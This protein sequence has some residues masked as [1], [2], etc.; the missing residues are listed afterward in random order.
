MIKIKIVCVGKLKED[1]YLKAQAEYVKMLGRFCDITVDELPDEPLSNVKGEKAEQM[2]KEAE[3][4]RILSRCD[5]FVIAC[6]VAAKQLSS[7]EFAQKT[8]ALMTGGNSTLCF[9]IGGSLG[10]SQ[11]VLS[12]ADMRLSVSKMTLP[13]RL[14][15]IV[16]L[17]QV[18]RAFKIINHETYHK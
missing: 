16:L 3:G 14:F 11:E 10:L 6:D 13:H 4:K 2:V 18:F 8:D 12:R 9:V 1:F 17:E 15:R 5:G 7:E